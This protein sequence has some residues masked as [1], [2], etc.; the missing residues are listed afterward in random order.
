MI[1]DECRNAVELARLRA[2]AIDWQGPT[3]PATTRLSFIRKHLRVAGMPSDIPVVD[4][5]RYT[6]EQL[7]LLAVA[8]CEKCHSYPTTQRYVLFVY[9]AIYTY[10]YIYIYIYI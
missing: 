7:A 4:V 10:I 3:F 1:I 9:Y 8:Q 2:A 5:R 6:W